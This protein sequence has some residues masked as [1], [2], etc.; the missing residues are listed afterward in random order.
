MSTLFRARRRLHSIR[1]FDAKKTLYIPVAEEILEEVGVLVSP[2][3]KALLRLRQFVY[4]APDSQDY[5]LHEALVINILSGEILVEISSKTL[6]LLNSMTAPVPVDICFR[7]VNT[8]SCMHSAIDRVNLDVIFYKPEASDIVRSTPSLPHSV[9]SPAQT[10]ALSRVVNTPPGAPVLLLGPFGTGK[11]QTLAEAVKVLIGRKNAN[12]SSTC[13]I[14]ICTHSNSA[15]D[16]Y[17][18]NYLHPFF[19]QLDEKSK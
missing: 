18:E 17:I 2:G 6:T 14:L 1:I 15:A 19:K 5:V 3:S 11:T 9:L 12:P 16:H 4:G 8:F 7:F 10:Q 13:R